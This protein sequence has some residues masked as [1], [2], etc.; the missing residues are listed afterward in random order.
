MNPKVRKGIAIAVLVIV[1]SA[2]FYDRF[3]VM[4]QRDRI[5]AEL[6]DLAEDMSSSYSAEQIATLIGR[7]G[8]I[9]SESKYQ[10]TVKYRWRGFSWN[11]HDL[12]VQF[13]KRGETTVFTTVSSEKSEPFSPMI[14]RWQAEAA[15]ES[16]DAA[17]QPVG[18]DAENQS[19]RGG[20]LIEG[21]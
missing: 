8:E 21:G 16:E 5:H 13:R 10:K 12:Y 9:V 11:P 19:R 1:A 7:P 15:K 17:A 14:E 4:R 2:F 20:G 3:V 18:I 6:M